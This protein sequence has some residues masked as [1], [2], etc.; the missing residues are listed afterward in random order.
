M[1]SLQIP[2]CSIAVALSLAA[3]AS[4]ASSQLQ[5][6]PAKTAGPTQHKVT[7]GETM[8][9]IAQKHQTSVGE[10]IAHNKLQ[11]HIVREGM[12][13]K[14]PSREAVKP[15]TSTTPSAPRPSREA[16]HVV[17]SGDTFWTIAERYKISAQA[18]AQANP[19]INPNRLHP[20]MEINVPPA[21]IASSAQKTIPSTT[22]KPSSS[23]TPSQPA[24]ASR[25]EHILEPGETFY[26]ISKKR[27]IKLADLVAANPSLK[28]ER[29]K[30]GTKIN[31]PGY[32]ND[33]TNPNKPV[34][35][36]AAP[37]PK[38]VAPAAP[39]NTSVTSTAP[40]KRHTVIEGDSIASIA[41]RYA[42]STDAL[43][44]Q[45]HLT[46]SD[47][48]YIG[49][50][51][52]I[53]TTSSGSSASTAPKTASVKPPVSKPEPAPASS[54]A[55]AP[56]PTPEPAATMAS[57]SDTANSPAPK[58]AAPAP[59]PVNVEAAATIPIPPP[60]PKLHAPLLV[61]EDGSIRSYI[62]SHGETDETICEAF[63][64]T[65]KELYEHN[66]LSQG[67]QLRPGDEIM[68]PATTKT[69]VSR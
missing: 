7:K 10:I 55:P 30:P 38:P 34:S 12:T 16:V 67:T 24:V 6:P 49:D 9:S 68:I 54:P 8:W 35:V 53:P 46:D 66:K 65:K 43:L 56:T 13:L 48:I 52:T 4:A 14:I 18:L 20:D 61:A 47:S 15:I 51:L 17:K 58:T 31:I 22:L 3:P 33:N 11:S 19:N 41:E 28:P 60:K 42:I 69:V 29:L 26:S 45:N 32:S 36:A 62:V 37:A 64:I 63:G 57:V 21:Q 23:P 25:G 40:T 44:K 1:H 39:A 5:N 27:G 50:V 59:Q 2:I